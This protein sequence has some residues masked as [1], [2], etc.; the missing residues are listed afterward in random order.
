[1]LSEESMKENIEMGEE[2]RVTGARVL[3]GKIMFV[4]LKIPASV[5]NC[6]F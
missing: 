5:A 4:N 3:D 1:M 2:L 6:W